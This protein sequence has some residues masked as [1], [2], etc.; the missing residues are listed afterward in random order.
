M[1][2]STSKSLIEMARNGIRQIETAPKADANEASRVVHL[3]LASYPTQEPKDAPT[4]IRQLIDR[5]VGVD[6]DILKRMVSPR[7]GIV[8]KQTFLP[9]IA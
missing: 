8:S 2:P 6:L 4:Y 1:V 5:C 3:L 9:S 7:E